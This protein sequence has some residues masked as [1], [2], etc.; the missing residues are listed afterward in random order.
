MIIRKPFAFI[1][2]RF[3]LLHFITFILCGYLGYTFW[4][5]SSFF[6]DF[7]V[8]GYTTN[9]ADVPGKYYSIFMVIAIVIILIFTIMLTTLFKR[10]NKFHFPYL[11]LTIFYV[12]LLLYTLFLPG[13]LRAAELSEIE[14]SAALILRGVASILFYG[15]PLSMIVILLLA[16][17]FDIRT[18]EFLDIKDEINLDEEDSEEVEINIKNEDYKVKRFTR[19]YLRE[20]KYYIIE[21]KNIFKVLGIILGAIILFFVGK[22]II[23]L[24]R[25]VKVD[26]SFRYSNISLTFNQS[27]LSTLDYGGNQISTD[28]V[29][30]AVKVKA[31]NNTNDLHTIATE[32][33][34]LEIANNTCLYPKLDKSGKF[35]DLA[36]PY[37]GE[38]IGRGQTYEYVLVYELEPNQAR[39]KYKIKILDSLVYKKDELIPK[40]KEITLTP[41]FSNTTNNIKDYN[42]QE[43]ILFNKTTLLN[44]KLTVNSYEISDN[45]RYSYEYCYQENCSESKNAIVSS[46]GKTFLV[47]D[48]TLDLD[49]EA[50]YTKYKLGTNAFFSDF[51]KVEYYID[52]NRYISTTTEKTPKDN[53]TKLV[54]EVPNAIKNADKINLIITIRDK[55][56]TLKLKEL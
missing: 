27:V 47:L 49:N 11:L 55:S 13:L 41:G 53:N 50:T 25:I 42:L 14:S 7:V 24:N 4:R 56:Y 38:K 9:I 19:R 40:Y 21:N 34:C 37:Y 51:A 32:D 18:G 8:Q 22:F 3:K 12:I 29:Y 52:G 43:E 36:K 28:K 45:Y 17:G 54:V 6:N 5:V 31:L 44:T 1:V 10:K 20:I 33:F 23:S 2:Q 26:Q 39:S 46:S 16:F 48:G 30:L 15:I 35:I